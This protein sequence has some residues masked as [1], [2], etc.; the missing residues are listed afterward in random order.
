MFSKLQYIHYSFENKVLMTAKQTD[1]CTRKDAVLTKGYDYTMLGW[2]NHS[3][4]K[5]IQ[6]YWCHRHEL[7]VDD[8]CL[9]WGRHVVVIPSPLQEHMLAELHEKHLG[10]F[11]ES[12]LSQ[13][14]SHLRVGKHG[15]ESLG[16]R[17]GNS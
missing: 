2:P 5:A 9:L 15:S 4:N 6:P 16:T 12:T 14:T 10:M 8:G 13:S 11:T 1:E 7:L 17:P 3:T